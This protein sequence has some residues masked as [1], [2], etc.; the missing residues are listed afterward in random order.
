MNLPKPSVQP[1]K[2][3]PQ[4]PRINST[5]S[6]V[7]DEV[8]R[9]LTHRQ[10]ALMLTMTLFAVNTAAQFGAALISNSLALLGDCGSMAVDTLSYAV[11]LWA[12]CMESEKKQRN[13]L[14]ATLWSI[15]V[16]LGVT[17]FVIYSA[18]V[19]LLCDE[20]DDDDINSY[21]VFA[22]ALENLLLDFIGLCALW[23]CKKE[24]ST[25]A[26]DLNLHSAGMHVISDLMRS[27]TTFI[28]SIL[29]WFYNFEGTGTDAVAALIVSALI[30]VPCAQMIRQWLQGYHHYRSGARELAPPP[31]DTESSTTHLNW[32]VETED[33]ELVSASY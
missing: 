15:F 10:R 21:I 33:Y 6:F 7:E 29:I 17:G 25:A 3:S 8:E 5:F 22:F 1:L 23:R 31:I 13:Q 28:E 14:L 2:T 18:I 30:L 27:T 19:I 20:L 26:S 16:L 9:W 24:K 4:R 11:N 12:E 32:N